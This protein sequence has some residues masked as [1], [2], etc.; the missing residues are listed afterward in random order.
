MHSSDD[1]KKKFF[2]WMRVVL[3]MLCLIAVCSILKFAIM[4]PSYARVIIHT[5]ND[6]DENY[7]TIVL[8]ASHGR[9][10]INPYKL[11]EKIGGNSLNV[12]MPDETIKDSYYL[13][14]EAE[15]TNNVK[16]VILDIDYQYWYGL[17]TNNFA[18]AF[19]YDQLS[20]SPVKVQY[21]I[22]NLLDEDFRVAL[23]RWAGYT[24]LLKNEKNN[25]KTKL[26]KDYFDYNIDCVDNRDGGGPYVGKGFFYRNK[27]S[28]N[29][30]FGE[31]KAISFDAD[32]VN[33]DTVEMFKKIVK[34][35]KDKN[36]RLVCVTSPITPS[37]LTCSEYESVNKYFTLLCEQQ[38]VEYYD[39]NYIKENV[40]DVEDDDFVDYEGHMVGE[41]A[42][43]Y[44]LVLGDVINKTQGY[45]GEDVSA[46]ESVVADSFYSSYDDMSKTMNYV[47][48][49]DFEY[50]PIKL[51]DG[52]YAIKI[53]TIIDSRKN[54]NPECR[55]TIKSMDTKDV[56][57]DSGYSN[58]MQYYY[59][60][61]DSEIYIAI[62][63][64][65]RNKG[66]SKEYE[67]KSKTKKILL[68]DETVNKY[69]A[70]KNASNK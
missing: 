51:D 1:K 43:K 13:L 65:G 17:K 63:A 11:D 7:D 41:L 54:V 6:K 68:N 52:R 9:S 38:D 23:T 42:N 18:S 14:K 20:L 60:E 27:L 40:L 31:F 21:F 30:G 61:F 12:S 19:I 56:L 25:L 58:N 26:S 33:K 70:K 66:S 35:C 29:D 32:G 48:L 69:I 49:T 4:P 44:S 64:Y 22:D 3:F 2:A 28:E 47:Q 37:M 15:R 16:T 36:I 24:Y 8:G 50:E 34:Y 10:A 53:N 45:Y 5:M 62:N 55:V 67:A 59:C 57:Y 46:I 39:F